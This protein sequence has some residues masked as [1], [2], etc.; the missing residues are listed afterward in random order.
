VAPGGDPAQ[1]GIL[2]DL[3]PLLRASSLRVLH[4]AHVPAASAAQVE[5]LRLRLPALRRLQVNSA[6]LV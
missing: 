6:A 4:L 3:S 2:P 1:P 5:E